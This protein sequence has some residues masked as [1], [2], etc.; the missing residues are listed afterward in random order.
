MAAVEVGTLPPRVQEEVTLG[1]VMKHQKLF[2]HNYPYR[3]ADPWRV[4]FY[5]DGVLHN[6]TPTHH[7]TREAAQDEINELE[8]IYTEVRHLF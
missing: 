7:P 5:W 4:G 2:P 8:E 6:A 3:A 1:L